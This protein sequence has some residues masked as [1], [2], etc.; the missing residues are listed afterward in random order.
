LLVEDLNA[1]RFNIETI[2]Q[3]SAPFDDV[4]V[5]LIEMEKVSNA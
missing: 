1:Q 3:K 5:K 4:F 2:E